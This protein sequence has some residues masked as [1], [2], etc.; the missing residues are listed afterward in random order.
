MQPYF[1][2]YIGYFQLV[3]AVDTFVVY[4]DVQY[5]KGGWINRNR[6]LLKGQPS[7]ITLPVQKASINLAINQRHYQLN[8]I[9]L[10]NIEHKLIQCYR[11]AP[12]FDEIF[13]FVCDLMNYQNTNVA[14]FNFNLIKKIAQRLRINATILLSSSLDADINLRGQEKVI[15]ICNKVGARQYTNPIAGSFLYDDATF[16][17]KGVKLRFLKSKTS[18]YTQFS[19]PALQSLSIIDV[20]MFNGPVAINNLLSDYDVVSIQSEDFDGSKHNLQVT[21]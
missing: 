13:P 11:N 7:W 15:E 14:M 1:F 12:L 5:M 18:T 17:N 9:T 8:K 3:N 16:A 21:T 10:L 4:D 6:I 20:L 19:E 2:P